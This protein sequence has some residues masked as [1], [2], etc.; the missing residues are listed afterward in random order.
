[1][2]SVSGEYEGVYRIRFKDGLEICFTLPKGEL[3]G[4]LFG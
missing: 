2:N 4:L 1:M 3:S